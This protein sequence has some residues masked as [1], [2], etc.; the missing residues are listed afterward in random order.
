MWVLMLASLAVFVFFGAKVQYEEDITKLLPQDKDNVG[1]LTFGNIRVKDKIFLQFTSGDSLLD[2]STLCSLEDEFMDSLQVRDSAAGR[3]ANSLYKF[4]DDLPVMALGY[5]MTH[6]PSFIDTSAYAFFD[7]AAAK[8]YVDSMMA[9]DYG[10]VMDDWTGSSTQMVSTDPLGLRNVVIGGLSPGFSLVDG[11][12]FCPDSTVA[13]AFISPNF[14]SFDFGMGSRLCEEIKGLAENF[15]AAHPG[16]KILVHGQAVRSAVNAARIKTDLLVTVG[17]SLVIILLVLILCFKSLRIVLHTLCPILW[18]TFFALSCMYW[19]KGGMSL[20]ALGI[21]AIVLGVAMSYC[22]HVIIHQKFT[23]DA[24]T[25]LRD[26]ST[27]VIL[28]CLTTVGAFAGLLFTKSELLRDFGL[29]ASFALIGCTFFALVFTP[30]FLSKRDEGKSEKAFKFIDRINNYPYERKLPVIAAVT[31][32]VVA[33]CLFAPKVRFDSDLKHLGYETPELKEA[34]DLYAQKNQEGLLQRYYAALG[35]T[36][37][38][39]LEADAALSSKLDSLRRSG[40]IVS[41]NG[42]V[43]RLFQSEKTQRERI[44]QWKNYW[45][46]ERVDSLM[47]EISASARAFGLDPEMFSPFR[48]M[49]TSDYEPGD[50]YGAGILP[51]GLLSNFIEQT[52]DGTYM[53]FNSALM[54]ENSQAEVDFVMDKKAKAAVVDPFYYMNNLVKIIHDDFNIVLWVSSLFVLL[55]LLLSF[56]NLWVS[57][58]AFLPMFLSW[59]VDEGFMAIFGLQFNLINIVI[60]T[61]IFGIGVD[62]SIFVMNGLLAEARG[63]GSNL[64]EYHKAAIFFSA[65]ALL[66]VMLALLSAVHPAISSIGASTLIGMVSTVLITYTLEPFLFRQAMKV[67]FLARSI[68]KTGGN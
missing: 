20:M 48:V 33:G 46:G 5:A 29:F 11:H 24:Q 66:V 21:G 27:P 7:E 54:D 12:I 50:L 45:T 49:L 59:Y 18:G 6:V 64:L 14:T 32:I 16:L 51:E 23:L 58:L 43:S 9:V 47:N 67:D 17:L 52:S 53:V 38:D 55:I 2:A 61:F 68:K 56:R 62:Y 1:A 63:E 35:T 31:L 3:I 40:D 65:L 15:K 37:D 10:L 57:V 39:A 22:L 60:S 30:Q 19:I 4:D 8:P 42:V 44:A 41:Y 26:E 34:Q 25:M 28:G 36:L 13:L